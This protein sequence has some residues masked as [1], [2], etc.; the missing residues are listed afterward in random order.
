MAYFMWS[1]EVPFE[2]LS[3]SRVDRILETVDPNIFRKVAD[4][5]CIWLFTAEG[6][7]VILYLPL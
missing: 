4:T 3:F 2:K 6:I 7:D 5:P 1:F